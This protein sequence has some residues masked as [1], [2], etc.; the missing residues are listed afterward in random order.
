MNWASANDGVSQEQRSANS[1]QVPSQATDSGRLS[2]TWP[3]N[4]LTAAE[5]AKLTYLSEQR[6]LDLAD[7]RYVPHWRI[8]GG[9]PLFKI[10]ELKSWILENIA[11][12]NNGAS[13][14]TR[15]VVIATGQPPSPQ[16]VPESI[17]G[18]NNLRD[19]SSMVSMSGIYFL[20][21]G[22]AVVYVGQSVSVGGRIATH[23]HEGKKSF[24]R[25]FFFSWPTYD[26]NRME[27]ALIRA[28]RPPLNGGVLTQ[29]SKKKGTNPPRSVVAPK[30][31]D[32]QA[33]LSEIGFDPA[34]IHLSAIE[35]ESRRLEI[36][37]RNLKAK[38]AQA[39]TQLLLNN[40]LELRERSR[41][42]ALNAK[43]DAD[44]VQ[45]KLTQKANR[46]LKKKT[47]A[48][49]EKRLSDLKDRRVK[50]AACHMRLTF[51]CRH[52]EKPI[53]QPEWEREKRR[54]KLWLKG[55]LSLEYMTVTK[56][57]GL[58]WRI[59]SSLPSLAN[60]DE[61]DAWTFEI[62]VAHFDVVQSLWPEG[63]ESL[64]TIIWDDRVGVGY[65]KRY[66]V[67]TEKR[68]WTILRNVSP[69]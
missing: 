33:A 12:F 8:D 11:E 23:I 13:L 2:R 26:L 10:S 41:I 9:I 59:R 5:A 43:L 36:Q 58:S 52:V 65:S 44:R 50:E 15:I 3:A 39:A 69:S 6:L 56:G 54:A 45:E 46:E 29:K 17:R 53:S 32:I 4:L 14:P 24:D 55:M 28:L 22:D 48:A 64:A 31:D 67:C 25:A 21:Q 20:C 38:S 47:A 60:N 57:N 30:V 51:F 7:S 27:G 37:A 19:A 40:Q 34:S 63:Q 61:Y 42:S 62:D 18:I 49:E 16:D 1:V 35:D 66:E 68:P